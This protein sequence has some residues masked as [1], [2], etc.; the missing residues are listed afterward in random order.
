MD[1]QHR[2]S[3]YVSQ[4]EAAS[5]GRATS[6]SHGK[7]VPQG[8][9]EAELSVDVRGGE[10]AGRGPNQRDVQLD[11]MYSALRDLQ[12]V[13]RVRRHNY[14]IQHPVDEYESSSGLPVAQSYVAFNDTFGFVV[15][16]QRMWDLPSK[17]DRIVYALPLGTTLAVAKLGER[18]V[19]LYNGVALV[20]QSLQSQ[21][22]GSILSQ[23]D[24][25][26]LL[27]SGCTGG[28]FYFGLEGFADEIYGNA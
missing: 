21:R 20:T 10:A 1:L 18:F 27:M 7:L 25:R 8:G 13:L 23:D 28:G 26:L 24:D 5:G 16:L 9:L 11:Y 14:D 15:Q 17:I 2:Q 4:G 19:P 12:D 6:P 3:G 22:I